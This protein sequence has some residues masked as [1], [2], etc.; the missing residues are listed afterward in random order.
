M[1]ASLWDLQR[2]FVFGTLL[3]T[4]EFTTCVQQFY[5]TVIF[6]FYLQKGLHLQWEIRIPE[7]PASPIYQNIEKINEPKRTLSG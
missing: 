3:A 2:L 5:R 6:T 7:Q 1:F 4:M